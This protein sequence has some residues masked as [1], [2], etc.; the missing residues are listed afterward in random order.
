MHLQ[1]KATSNEFLRV[2]PPVGLVEP[3]AETQVKLLFTAK[4]APVG[5]HYIA[6]YHKTVP[7]SFRGKAKELWTK[8]SIPEGV[9]RLH[10]A[11][12]NVTM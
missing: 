7:D 4:E 11:F 6:I 9:R 5:F 3:F 12:E 2:K 1:I 10:M 8:D